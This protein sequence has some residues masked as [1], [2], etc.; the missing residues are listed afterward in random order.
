MHPH[1]NGS[2]EP[3]AVAGPPFFLNPENEKYL[4]GGQPLL[5]TPSGWPSKG[6]AS[7]FLDLWIVFVVFIL[8]LPAISWFRDGQYR[9]GL[10]MV[11]AIAAL[12]FGRAW[13]VRRH[14]RN[15]QIAKREGKVMEGRVLTS[16]F[17]NKRNG[18]FIW[19][20]YAL[21]SPS[22]KALCGR[23]QGLLNDFQHGQLPARGTLVLVFCV[24]DKNFQML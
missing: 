22:G 4:A 3:E 18:D 13:D 14:I 17:Q 1:H 19:V 24:N 15:Q 9:Q 20:Q 16:G 23:N 7:L 8:A 12:L 21:R 10:L 5:D 2:E 11:A 6:H